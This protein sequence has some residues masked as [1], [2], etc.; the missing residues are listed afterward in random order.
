[1]QRAVLTGPAAAVPGFAGALE[2]ELGLPVSVGELDVT[3]DDVPAGR[4]TV[5]AGLAVAEAVR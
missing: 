1:M 2:A 4:L 5:A 3:H